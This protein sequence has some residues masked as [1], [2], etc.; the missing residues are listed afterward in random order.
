[1]ATWVVPDVAHAF[2]HMGEPCKR[3][4][5]MNMPSYML[6]SCLISSGKGAEILTVLTRMRQQS[7][8]KSLDCRT[9]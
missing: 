3:K 9:V 8:L 6:F 7:S 1:M 4:V 2:G 5:S